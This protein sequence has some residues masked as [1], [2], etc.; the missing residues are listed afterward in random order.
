[1]L[2]TLG[3]GVEADDGDRGTHVFEEMPAGA[4]DGEQVVVV[5][6]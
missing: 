1:V 3:A 6:F 2:V 4:G 5:G